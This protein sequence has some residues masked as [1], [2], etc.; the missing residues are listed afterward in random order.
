MLVDNDG[1]KFISIDDEAAKF[2][3]SS[4]GT[5]SF[6]FVDGTPSP[7]PVDPPPVDPPPVDPLPGEAG[8]E[9]DASGEVEKDSDNQNNDDTQNNA[10]NQNNDSNKIKLNVIF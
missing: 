8:S 9:E 4:T 3:L 7:P 5:F 6:Y 10:D 2:E 1:I